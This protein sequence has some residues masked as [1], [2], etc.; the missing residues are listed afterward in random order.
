M[1]D[2]KELGPADWI[3]RILIGFTSFVITGSLLHSEIRKRRLSTTR[4]ASGVLRLTSAGSL[5]CAP[6]ASLL[7]VCSV[8][9]GS[10]MFSWGGAIIAL[11]TQLAF[12]TFYQLSRLYY[13]FSN[14]KL[15]GKHGYPTC[16][17]LVMGIVGVIIWISGVMLKISVNT[18]PSKCGYRNDMF[19][20]RLRERSILFDGNTWEDKREIL[21][22]AVNGVSSL[23]WDLTTLLLYSYKIWKIRAVYNSK[24]DL[25][26]DNLLFIL[27]RI[28]IISVFYQGFSAFSGSLWTARN[29]LFASNEAVMNFVGEVVIAC[30]IM[31]FSFCMFM[32]MDHNTKTYFHFLYLLRRIR[33]KYL[34]FCDK[35]VDQQIEHLE[36]FQ[37]VELQT[38]RSDSRVDIESTMFPDLSSHIGADLNELQ[39]ETGGMSLNTVTVVDPYYVLMQE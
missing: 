6:I 34:C 20:Y 9:P 37:C 14:R 36:P 38:I 39:R 19:F 32:M 16:L 23:M 26:W 22:N 35:M 31:V 3:S 10:C 24:Q 2:E 5:W 12:L 13:C 25:I 27:H 33:L 29:L 21:W 4:F 30:W 11:Y 15:H 28:V 18:L 8:I 1:G 17:F 7:L